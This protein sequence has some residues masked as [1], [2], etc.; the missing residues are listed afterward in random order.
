M[1][2]RPS[3][4]SSQPS[5]SIRVGGGGGG[6]GGVLTSVPYRTAS[7]LSGPDA[8]EPVTDSSAAARRRS[9][10]VSGEDG[11]GGKEDDEDPY[12]EAGDEVYDRLS[13]WR[14]SCIVGVL[15]F[16]AFLSPISS[17]SVL[18]ATP[19]VAATYGT[20]GS[21][22]NLSN[23]GYM[24]LMAVSPIV[25]GPISQLFGRRPITLITAVAFTV[26]SMATALAPNLVDIYRPTERGTAVGWFMSGTLFGPAFGPFLGGIIVTYSSWRTIFW[27]QTGLAG[28]GLAGVFFLVPET[29]HRK[30]MDDLRQQQQ[31][32]RRRRRR[33]RRRRGASSGWTGWTGRWSQA[34]A[35]ASQANPLRIL[36]W[37]RHANL[38][39]VGAASAALVWNMY[40]LLTPIRYVLNP[41]FGLESPLLSGLFYL[42]PGSGY[43]LGTFGGGRWADRTVKEW[44]RR[45]GGRR[46]PEDRIRSAVPFIGL[47]MPAC[48]LVYGW[49]VEM[50]AGG[51]PVPVIA[52]FAQGVGQ[53]FC[54]PSL[55]TYCLDVVGGRGAEVAAANFFVRYLSGCL[56][57]AVVLP[58]VEAVGIGWFS[59]I[60]AGL[61]VASAAGLQLAIRRGD[62]WVERIENGPET[63]TGADG[64]GVGDGDGDGDAGSG[65]GAGTGAGAGAGAGV[66]G[67][68]HYYYE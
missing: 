47:L 50:R 57:T 6:G 53:L 55:N 61:L 54:F 59:T 63:G 8:L 27:L 7:N 10:P 13:R 60:S 22:V 31:Q 5:E 34:R 33:R 35:V 39:L 21:I 46:V 67:D 24:A 48:V 11:A 14:K 30:G 38:C 44:I 56:G 18:S 51:I 65:A 2:A 23:A 45:R 52:M 16:C 29:I 19:E 20:T 43:L 66:A 58:I 41:R 68:A 36:R 37:F 26:L 49:T 17:T 25:W 1:S 9:T 40:S 28:A 64:D 3:Y 42:A 4:Q 62:G 12:R 15:A 32:Q